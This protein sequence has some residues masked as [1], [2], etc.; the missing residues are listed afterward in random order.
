[1]IF[2][3]YVSFREGTCLKTLGFKD[4]LPLDFNSG[5]LVRFFEP[6]LN[7]RGSGDSP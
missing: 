6:V 2:M 5:I 3:G 4:K 1:M 7:G